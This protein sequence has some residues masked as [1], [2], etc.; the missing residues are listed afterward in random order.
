MIR[1]R[2]GVVTSLDRARPGLTEL[3]VSL[4]GRDEAAI[5]YPTRPRWR[6][7]WGRAAPTS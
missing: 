2:R 3:T 7:V 5:A 1:L 4:E 6:W